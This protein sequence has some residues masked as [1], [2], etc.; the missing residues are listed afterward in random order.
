M[1][2]FGAF[3]TIVVREIKKIISFVALKGVSG[4]NVYPWTNIWIIYLAKRVNNNNKRLNIEQPSLLYF[5]VSTS[6]LII[7]TADGP[8][9]QFALILFNT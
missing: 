1:S 6:P 4:L 5:K 8:A 3:E 2:D 7:T 9:L